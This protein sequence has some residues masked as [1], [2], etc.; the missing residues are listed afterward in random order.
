MN[1]FALI[2]F[3]RSL[4]RHKLYA[5]LNIGGL[6]VGIAVFL[7]LT[8][9]V[10]FETGYE[11]FL[12][13]HEQAYLLKNRWTL[14]GVKAADYDGSMGGLLEQLRQD[15]PE[16]V[17]TRMKGAQ[18]TVLRDGNATTEGAE[19]VDPS[20]FDVID[21]PVIEGDAR[22]ALVAPNN[23]LIS[24]KIAKKYFPGGH[25]IG[26]R[27][28]IALFGVS[29]DYRVAAILADAPRDTELDWDIV[30]RLVPT[31]IPGAN[32]YHWGSATLSTYLRFPN[33]AAMRSYSDRLP[34]FIDRRARH[35]FTNGRPS[36]QLAFP[37]V[38]I[39]DVHLSRPGGKLAVTTLGLVGVLTLLI[40]IINYVNLATARA[41]LRAREVAMRKVLGASR[42]ALVR[43][44][45]GEAIATAL[46][47]ALIGL[48]LAEMALP[49]VNAAGDVTLTI[50]YVFVVPLLALLAIVV[51]VAAGLYPAL[52][53]SRFPAAAVLA[54]ARSPG[55]GRTG[56]RLRE[57]LVVIQFALAIAF[58]IGTGV[59]FAQT[60]HL[61]SADLGFR[62]DGLMVVSSFGSQSLN[63]GQRASLLA[64]FRSLP[65]TVAVT[66]ADSAPG[67]ESYTNATGI[68]RPG[69]SEDS[70]PS[71]STYTIG[72]DWFATN[73]ARLAAGR[74]LDTA[75]RQDDSG[76]TGAG[77][78]NVV[79]NRAALS[80]FGFR[81]PDEAI[82]QTVLETEPDGPA[83]P[84]VIVGVIDDIRFHSPRKELAG[85]LYHYTSQPMEY[86]VAS[87]RFQG[88]PQI[89]LSAFRN[90]WRGIA[91]D[92]PFDAKTAAQSLTRYYKPD[93]RA[94]RLFGIGAGLAVLIGCVGLWGLAS[95]N[96][97]R[98][99]KEVG[100][101]KTLGASSTDIVRLLV[102]QFLR[103]VLIANLFAWPLAFL[104]MRTWLAGFE[105]RIA[106]S[107]LYFVAATA[108]SLLIAIATVIAQSLRAA[109]AAPA[110]ALRHE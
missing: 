32:W 57:G 22:A 37:L 80:K 54:S 60:S 46:A 87:V 104:A 42:G 2:S 41:G 47:A 58:L 91:P 103:P 74:F 56:T 21:V 7:V 13:H 68:Y 20:F 53:L 85:A 24:Q 101:R 64:A 50:D 76:L 84:R 92:V 90:A 52:L 99:V 26:Q 88:D 27:M 78:A 105:D 38:P 16:T 1:R 67:D 108:I 82:G 75:H 51:G 44:F 23:V 5:A 12:P 36:D 14:H 48:A 45:L 106:L 6:A 55:G 62:R 61:R 3:Y 30:M 65:M 4:V 8:L 34:G 33:E 11:T 25:A 59:L 17:G 40:A 96:T 66:T 10:R 100:I 43:H 81:S 9:Y 19:L 70:A 29:R 110:W 94:A 39:R 97:A 73:D 86:T 79:I 49:V 102:G 77:T 107:P 83:Q 93:D 109:R 98:R 31:Q 89:A 72:K 71:I 18:A 69:Q 15:F 95:F 28:T 63:D 35:D